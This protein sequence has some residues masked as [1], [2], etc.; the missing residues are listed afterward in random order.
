MT[1]SLLA[2]ALLCTVLLA[3]CISPAGTSESPTPT[4]TDATPTPTDASSAT[5]VP[6]PASATPPTATATGAPVTVEYT[7]TVG[8]LPDG[9]DS[10][11]ATARVVLVETSDDVGPCWRDTF[12]GPY[13]PTPTPIARPSG[14]CR[15]SDPVSVDLTAAGETRTLNVTAPERFDAGHALLVA[16][17]TAT[18]ENGTAVAVRE[19]TGHRA[20]V[21]EG[22]P[23]DPYRVELTLVAAPAGAE[24]DYSV[25]SNVTAP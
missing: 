17:V 25:V 21:V 9:L 14:E 22:P 11:S 23:D 3:G 20:N 7:I 13:L 2:G 5:D 1:R 15:R 4:P 16:N 18:D 24:Y 6:P 12:S 10:A 8:D 19:A